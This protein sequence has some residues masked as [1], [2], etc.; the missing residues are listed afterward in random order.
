MA[1]FTLSVMLFPGHPTK[2]V[3]LVEPKGFWSVELH[4][5]EEVP[6]ILVKFRV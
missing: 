1:Y 2:G 6:V 3:S 5:Y 4:S